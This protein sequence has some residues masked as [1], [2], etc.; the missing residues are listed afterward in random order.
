M[1]DFVFNIAKGAFA[2]YA[3][4]DGGANDGLGALLLETS[5]LEAD[6]ALKDHDTAAA[7]LAGA[8]TEQTTMGRK[9]LASVVVT[10]D[11][12]EDEVRVDVADLLYEDATGDPVG[13]LVTFYDPDTTAGDD[14]DLIPL[15]GHDLSVTPDGNDIEIQIHT[16]GIAVAS[17]PA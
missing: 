13:K 5:G 1:A 8:S 9:D 12:T 3:R 2:W 16:D 11:D 6:A 17:E 7:I 14:S 15:T 4:L 10:V